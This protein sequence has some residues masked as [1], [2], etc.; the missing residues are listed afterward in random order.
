LTLRTIRDAVG[1]TQAD[2]ARESQIDQGDVSR[3]ENRSDLDD[4]QVA[5]LRR[6]VEALGGKLELVA[7]FGDKKIALVGV[8]P[9]VGAGEQAN[10][11]LQRTAAR[12]PAR[13]R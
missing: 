10:T 13:R 6:Y 5:T 12:S 4:C 1:K 9:P 2:V 7:S 3:L 11:P 8:E